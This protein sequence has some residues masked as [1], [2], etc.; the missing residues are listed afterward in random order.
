ML[1]SELIRELGEYAIDVITG[2]PGGISVQGIK[3]LSHDQMAFSPE[4]LY[5]AS[6][7]GTL[8][9]LPKDTGVT[10]LF[11]NR[12]SVPAE[13]LES[14]SIN[15]LI[16]KGNMPSE[17]IYNQLNETLTEDPLIVRSS[18]KLMEALFSDLGLQG[19]VNVAFEITG[20]PIYVVDS[21]YKY[22]AISHNEAPYKLSSPILEEEKKLGFIV[23]AGIHLIKS[24]RL[25]ETVRKA[26]RPFYFDNPVLGGGSLIDIIRIHNVEV[27]HVMMFEADKPFSRFDTAIL[28]RLANIISLELQKRSFYKNNKG[29]MYSYFLAD[30]LD[31]GV[32][33]YKNANE[34]L[35]ILGFTLRELLYVVV[36]DSVHNRIDNEPHLEITANQL[37]WLLVGSM[38]V[39]YQGKIVMLISRSNA[40]ITDNEYSDVDKYLATNSLVAG[41]SRSFSDMKDI[42]KYYRQALKAAELGYKQYHK[43]EFYHYKDLSFSHMLSICA[44]EENLLTFCNPKLLRLL[45]YDKAHNTELT[46]T[47]YQYLINSQNS[48]KT[49]ANLH[50]HKNT[51]LYRIEKIKKITDS[52]MDDG[53]ELMQLHMSFHIL[54]YLSLI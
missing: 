17:I 28:S 1:L 12:E 2:D 27:G 39:I 26:T 6:G 41:I 36:V 48:V 10:V 31:N 14:G 13:Y 40:G 16:P 52:P 9:A 50:I 24:K 4:I 54:R 53:E 23:D 5:Y 51:L 3:L 25:D 49:A 21:S 8:P 38:Y 20:H 47:L 46:Q 29:V 32:V 43:P 18:Q 19:I 22:L 7:G 11:R 33:N 44:A 34:R 30:L 42:R 37:H 35:Q 15:I 45:E